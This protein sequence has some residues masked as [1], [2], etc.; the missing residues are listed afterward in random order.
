MLSTS[1]SLGCAAVCM[2]NWVSRGESGRKS[3]RK[4][5]SLI[6]LCR[7]V[8]AIIKALST[9][10]E[11]NGNFCSKRL[12]NDDGRTVFDNILMEAQW[13]ELIECDWWL[14]IICQKCGFFS[15]KIIMF[16]TLAR[17]E[18]RNNNFHLHFLSSPH[19]DYRLQIFSLILTHFIWVE[20]SGVVLCCE[21][22]VE[23][24]RGTSSSERERFWWKEIHILISL[25]NDFFLSLDLLALS[26]AFL[27]P[28]EIF[29][30][31]CLLVW[32]E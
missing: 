23:S 17:I 15:W 7:R 22:L 30:L 6:K 25:W 8:W 18:S 16:A 12:D 10:T 24:W 26:I 11:I 9:V 3:S 19:T 4:L 1:S 28:L 13:N 20:R 21:C 14:K 32:N 5:S 31:D 2:A 27:S 29:N